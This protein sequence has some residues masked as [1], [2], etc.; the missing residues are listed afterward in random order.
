MKMA[1][2]VATIGTIQDDSWQ[3]GAAPRPQARGRACSAAEE[4]SW[5]AYN[6]TGA[7][8]REIRAIDVSY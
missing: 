3:E 2:A 6:T 8:N 1:M 4:M 7:G 5:S